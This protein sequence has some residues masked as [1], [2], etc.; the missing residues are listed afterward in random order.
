MAR[1]PS[2]DLVKLESPSW[3]IR[4][5]QLRHFHVCGVEH[6][7]LKQEPHFPLIILHRDKRE[8]TAAC[9]T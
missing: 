5:P 1:K 3:E 6:T 2:R 8:P 4:D 7:W 9:E